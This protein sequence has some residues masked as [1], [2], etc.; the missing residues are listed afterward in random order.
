MICNCLSYNLTV[1]LCAVL[2]ISV[3]CVFKCVLT[4]RTLLRNKCVVTRVVPNVLRRIFHK[5]VQALRRTNACRRLSCDWTTTRNRMIGGSIPS[6]DRQL[7]CSST[8]VCSRTAVANSDITACRPG[9]LPHCRHDGARLRPDRRDLALFV[10]LLGRAQPLGEDRDDVPSLFR[11]T[12]VTV[13]LR[14]RDA[15]RQSGADRRRQ[16]EAQVPRRKR[17]YPGELLRES[18]GDSILWQRQ[19]S[20]TYGTRAT[21]G[22][23]SSFQWHAEAL[24]F[25]YQ[26]CYDSHRRYIDLDMYKKCMLLARWML[27]NLAST[28]S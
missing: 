27:W 3:G 25:T 28:H 12:V 20:A 7:L 21:P 15:R 18:S 1:I 9:A 13:P 8:C 2:L 17:R 6:P 10:R 26:L 19:G 22:T 14:L 24:C 4:L 23:P 16:L 5:H 11:A